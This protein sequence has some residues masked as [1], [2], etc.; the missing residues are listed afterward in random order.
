MRLYTKSKTSA[1]GEMIYRFF[2]NLAR[3]TTDW[4]GT[5]LAFNLALMTILIWI[6]TGPL[7]HYS[8]TWQLVINTSTTIITFL[9]VFL[10]QRA[11]NKDSLAMQMKLNEMLASQSGASNRLLSIEDLTEDEIRKI[12]KRFRSLTQRANNENNPHAVHSVE[13]V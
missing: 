9:M 1:G 7:F 13:E 4:A 8:D 11:H 5:T 2:E 6:A 3:W 12:Q 10:L